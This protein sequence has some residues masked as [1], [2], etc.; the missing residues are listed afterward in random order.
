MK[1]ALELSLPKS[2]DEIWKAFNNPENIKNWQ[3][4]LEKFETISGIQGQAGSVSKLTYKEGKRE[5]SLLEK[6]T[7]CAAPDRLDSAYENE[8]ADNSI[9]NTFV[10][11]SENETL[12]RVEV[13]FIFKTLLMKI[14]GPLM[15]TNYILRTERDMQRFKT[16][17]ENV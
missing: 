10:V 8:F 12:W 16:F 13:E 6:I 2:R 4:S 3:P 14:I 7:H 1:F 17:V 5:F 9:M 11:V 15:K